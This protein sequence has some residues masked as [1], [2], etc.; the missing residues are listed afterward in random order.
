MK[1]QLIPAADV[2]ELLGVESKAVWEAAAR[3]GVHEVF[4]RHRRAHFYPWQV[5]KIR[6]T[7][8]FLPQPRQRQVYI[9]RNGRRGEFKI[10]VTFDVPRRVMEIQVAS[11]RKLQIEHVEPG[12]PAL[13][14]QIHKAL[15]QHR[16]V[17]EWFKASAEVLQFVKS[18]K[19]SGILAAMA[20]VS[21]DSLDN[22]QDNSVNQDV[23]RRFS[24]P[25][26][27]V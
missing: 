11:P 26:F 19:S 8:P 14:R 1:L 2:C 15:A 17:G 22:S 3:A 12:S 24:A 27:I 13:E 4:D 9:L 16:M 25:G 5:E 23:S 18:A 7:L 21:G 10:G 6:E 20:Q